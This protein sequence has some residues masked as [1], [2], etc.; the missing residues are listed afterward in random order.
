MSEICFS[1]GAETFLEKRRY[2]FKA[3]QAHHSRNITNQ[4]KKISIEVN[5]RNILESVRIILFLCRFRVVIL[6]ILFLCMTISILGSFH[7]YY[8]VVYLKLTTLLESQRK[9]TLANV[10]TKFS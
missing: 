4:E 1:G 7:H 5:R 10:T 8:I 9:H 6:H 3:L 2:F